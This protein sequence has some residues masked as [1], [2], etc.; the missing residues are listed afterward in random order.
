MDEPT[1]HHGLYPQKHVF[2]KDLVGSGRLPDNVQQRLMSSTDMERIDIRSQWF[3]TPPRKR[4]HQPSTVL[5]E[6]V[7]SIGMAD[8]HSQM[9]K[10]LLQSI[11]TRGHLLSTEM[12]SI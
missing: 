3:D 6:G 11:A 12:A 9:S 4:Q 10:T 2:K 8:P 1:S 7:G 5:L